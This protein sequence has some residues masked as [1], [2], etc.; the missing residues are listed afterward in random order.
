[1]DRRRFLLTTAA[2]Q[3]RIQGANERIRAGIIGAGGRG[4]YLTAQFKEIGAE[5][6]A[7]CDVYEANLQGG[8][9]EAST[10]ARPFHDYRR[11]LEDKSIDAVIVATPDHWH[12][13]MVIDAVNAG[14]DVYVEKPMAHKI[15]EGFDVITAVRRTKR[16][17]Q[18]GM[19][20]RSAE[21][22]L[23]GKRIMDSGQLGNV[24]L[25]TSAWYNHTSSLR[26]AKLAGSLDWKQWL[27]SAPDRPLDP[28]RFF[29]WYYF[30]DYSG[31]LLI[32]QAA[33]ILDCIQWYMNSSEPVA[34]TCAGGRSNLPGAE[35]PETA[36]I[37]IEYPENYLAT[38]TLGYK[39]MRYNS[40]NDQLK[41]FHGTKAR[42][43]V[44][45]EWYA[46]Y[47]ESNAVE[48]K[49]SVEKKR[50]GSFNS[51]APSHIRNFLECI[52]SRRDPNAP[53]EA[54]QATNIV[55]CMTMDSLR[56]GRRLR[57]NSQTKKVEA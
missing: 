43:D 32:G 41:Q 35:V 48:M 23:E 12:A 22:F 16:V 18:V 31:G 13:R 11:L 3:A 56:Q 15:D 45:R 53:V 57:W 5:M 30:W 2:A 52:R 38:F 49:P 20:R 24:H 17:V 55:L 28:L 26:Q 27:G 14:K 47:P 8:L 19:Q 9:K 36:T 37:A 33:H 21:L 25:V 39:A 10:G 6:A 54:G 42:L 7:V 44:G 29:N 51:A 1:M 34:V 50:P 46:L 4:K 40:F